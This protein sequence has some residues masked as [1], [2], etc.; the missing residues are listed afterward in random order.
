MMNDKHLLQLLE[1]L[2]NNS[3][4]ARS[5]KSFAASDV[6]EGENGMKEREDQLCA[7]TLR[8][9]IGNSPNANTNTNRRSFAASDP[10]LSPN[11]NPR[12]S[13]NKASVL[14]FIFRN[15]V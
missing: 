5:S 15:K 6:I 2:G 12:S 14:K 4:I 1:R 7:V 9:I 10:S 3:R 11:P 13:V 8:K